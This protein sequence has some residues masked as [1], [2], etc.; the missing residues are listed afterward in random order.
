M[1]EYKV[2]LLDV[3]TEQWIWREDVQARTPKKAIEL[4]AESSEQAGKYAAVPARSWHQHPA[5]V[6]TITTVI[7]T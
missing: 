7:V 2:F 5:D 1:T 4:H 6:N 3:G